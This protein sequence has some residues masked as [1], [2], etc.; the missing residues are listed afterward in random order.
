MAAEG[1]DGGGC[2]PPA[3]EAEE[4]GG[5]VGCRDGGHGRVLDW[6]KIEMGRR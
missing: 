3:G 5:E 2:W 6:R 4:Y 1:E